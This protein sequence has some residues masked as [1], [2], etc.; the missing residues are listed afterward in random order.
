[1]ERPE[2]LFV[3]VRSDRAWSGENDLKR[4]RTEKTTAK[5]GWSSTRCCPF[6]SVFARIR[7]VAVSGATQWFTVNTAV[8]YLSAS[9]KRVIVGLGRDAMAKL[10][11][12]RWPSGIIQKI[13]NV[14]A[15]QMLT[16]DE[17]VP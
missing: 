1:M 7:V 16:V 15:D 2:G 8:G 12:M 4:A 11:E 3:F 10:I 17:I 6:R 9:D 14:R 13:E 5:T